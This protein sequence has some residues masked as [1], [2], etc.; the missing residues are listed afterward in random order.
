MSYNKKAIAD[1]LSKMNKA[2][3]PKQVNDIIMDP[4]GQNKFPGLPTRIPSNNITMETTPYPVLG[5]DNFG[6]EQM[7]YPGAN[8]TF[9]GADY[10]DEYPMMQIGGQRPILYVDPNDPAGVERYTAYNDSLDKFNKGNKNY[11]TWI[12]YGAAGGRG[13]FWRRVIESALPDDYVIPDQVNQPIGQKVT[14]ATFPIALIVGSRRPFGKEYYKKTVDLYA[15]PKQPVFYKD[16]KEHI[17]DKQQQLI[18][19]GYD[20]GKAD[21]IWGPKSQAAWEEF[22]KT[23]TTEPEVTPQPTPEQAPTLEVAPLDNT[24]QRPVQTQT[25]PQAAQVPSGYNVWT[26]NGQPLDPAVYGWAPSNSPRQISQFADTHSLK[27]ANEAYN[28]L[29]ATPWATTGNKLVTDLY[30]PYFSKQAA[31][32]AIEQTAQQLG[33]PVEQLQIVKAPAGYSG[34]VVIQ[35]LPQQKYGGLVT[36][37][38]NTSGNLLMNEQGKRMMAKSGSLYATNKLFLGNPLVT[39]R[40]K[41]VFVPGH[42]FQTGGEQTEST[43]ENPSTV[44]PRSTINEYYNFRR[45]NLIDLSLTPEQAREKYTSVNPVLFDAYTFFKNK[46]WTPVDSS[47]YHDED[48]RYCSSKGCF[49]DDNSWN[50]FISANSPAETPIVERP[51]VTPETSN[52]QTPEQP[53]ILPVIPLENVPQQVVTPQQPVPT[54]TPPQQPVQTNQPQVTPAPQQPSETPKSSEPKPK[55]HKEYN[56]YTGKNEPMSPKQKIELDRLYSRD[57]PMPENWQPELIE[58]YRRQSGGA[59]DW[60]SR[61]ASTLNYQKGGQLSKEE[62]EKRKAAYKKMTGRDFEPP[63]SFKQSPQAR[64]YY[65]NKYNQQPVIQSQPSETVQ[66]STGMTADEAEQL[67]IQNTPSDPRI[68]QFSFEKDN[69]DPYTQKRDQYY[70]EQITDPT[71]W[72]KVGRYIDAATFIGGN[73]GNTIFGGDDW[74]NS[75]QNFEAFQLNPYNS[76]KDKLLNRADMVLSNVGNAFIDI[77][78]AELGFVIPQLYKASFKKLLEIGSKANQRADVLQGVQ[79][80]LDLFQGDASAIGDIL[81]NVASYRSK[82]DNFDAS[83]V[84]HNL[85][86]W[87]KITKAE[88]I[89][90]AKDIFNLFNAVYQQSQRTDPMQPYPLYQK[91]GLASQFLERAKQA[92]QRDPKKFAEETR[93]LQ[94]QKFREDM[95]AANMPKSM[96]EAEAMIQSGQ[97]KIETIA[98]QQAREKREADARKKEREAALEAYEKRV[99]TPG[100]NAWT[101]LPGESWRDMLAAEAAPLAATFRFSQGDNFIDDYINPAVWIGSMAQNLGE[102]PQQAKETGSLLPYITSVGTPLLGGAM[103]GIGATNTGQFVNNMVN[104]VAGLGTGMLNRVGRKSFTPYLDDIGSSLNPRTVAN[105]PRQLPG[106]RVA[107]SVDD[108]G[109]GLTQTP[110]P[111]QMQELPGL[112]LKSTMENNPQG[113]HKYVAK[114]GS[115]DTK[116]ALGHIKRMEGDAK[117]EVV[118]KNLQNKYGANLEYLPKRMDY[119]TLRKDIQEGLWDIGTG[120]GQGVDMYAGQDMKSHGLFPKKNPTTLETLTSDTKGLGYEEGEIVLDSYSFTNKNKFVGG[121]DAHNM[122]KETLGHVRSFTNPKEPGVYYSAERQSNWAQEVSTTTDPIL[123]GKVKRKDI[124]DRLQRNEISLKESIKEQDAL[125]AAGNDTWA[126]SQKERLQSQL[127]QVQNEIESYNR[128]LKATPQEKLVMK[129]MNERMLQ[130]D[131]AYAA[132]Q[133]HTK[134]RLP[135]EETMAKIQGFKP[136][137]SREA[138]LESAKIELEIVENSEAYKKKWG[139]NEENPDKH[140]EKTLKE[141]EENPELFIKKRN[142]EIEKLEKEL[143]KYGNLFYATDHQTI[144]NHTSQSLKDAEKLFGVKLKPVTDSKGNTWYEFDIPKTFKKG[145]GEIKAFGLAPFIGIGAAGAAASQF[146]QGGTTEEELTPAQLAMMKARLAYAHMHGN[147]S[148]QRMVAPVDNPYIFTGNEPYASPD[149]AGYSGTHYMFSQGPFAVPTIQTGPDGQLYYNVNASPNDSEAMQFDSPEDAEV[150]ARYYKTVAPAFQDMEL[151]D[152]EIEEYK[153]G[154]CTIVKL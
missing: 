122:P 16:S 101:G 151:T 29:G 24:P 141:Y 133:G 150:F 17:Q 57:L 54:Q 31:T 27:R 153:R 4:E 135:S 30:K 142:D 67:K 2:R 130:E 59:T 115:I 70:A 91:G 124:H 96:A 152:E 60:K 46:G 58:T 63:K 65:Q 90:T 120:K 22:Q 55:Y 100:Y 26:H 18:D 148:A 93:K 110:Q 12:N 121:S 137:F 66:Q 78:T 139:I 105:T 56:P 23:Q 42:D 123:G 126:I 92:Q 117:Y 62:F 85:N 19:A 9:P 108:V 64:E 73:L 111:W 145:K 51:L 144:L 38:T 37:L 131:V 52:V 128:Y 79:G 20:I 143:K 32:N 69:R 87:N 14:E 53:P 109:R 13:P 7:M 129:N 40:K 114:D 47:T 95:T 8:Y 83:T 49:Y 48:F 33:V 80:A 132:S 94:M 44:L 113:L 25:P 11:L 112:H 71:G 3:K 84:Y 104:P 81:L 138:G 15:E 6:N 118:L 36:G 77:G 76:E 99:N 34:Y 140:F 89:D 43:I 134:Y 82:M 50:T 98:Q 68:N 154:G 116:S 107:S 119:N 103:L 72:N 102:S 35:N 146:Q 28:K 149:T 39:K 125:I 61:I 41:A 127:K 45:A 5:V 147:P 136:N 106:S 97:L 1:A 88:K 10:V 21:G 86:N 74:K 75:L